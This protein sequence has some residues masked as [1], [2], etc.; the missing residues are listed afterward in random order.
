MPACVAMTVSQLMLQGSA[1]TCPRT[2]DSTKEKSEWNQSHMP[3]GRKGVKAAGKDVVLAL[4]LAS[5][6]SRGRNSGP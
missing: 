5:A 1:V 2:K 6:R 3:S 4:C